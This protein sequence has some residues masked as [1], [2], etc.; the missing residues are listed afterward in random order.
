MKRLGFLVLVALVAIPAVAA[1]NSRE[2]VTDDV[3]GVSHPPGAQTDWLWPALLY[4]NGPLVT[5]PG[6]GAGGAD[7]SEL[8]TAL[9][10]TTLGAGHQFALGYSVSDDFEVPAG[11]WQ[12]D[13]ITFFAYQTGLTT[14]STVTGVYAQIWDGES[15]VGGSI[16]WGDLTTNLMDTTQW[17]NIYRATDSDPNNTD[18]PIMATVAMVNTTLTPGTYW[19]EWTTDGTLGSGPWAPPISILGETTTGNAKQNLAGA[20]QELVDGGTGTAQ[21]LP[22]II[23]GE[24]VPVELQSFSIE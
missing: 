18:R 13:T 11:G 15:D 2:L 17:S 24:V 9:G 1:D 19:V 10:L 16:V 21:G 22:F 3:P 23:D 4:D 6:G 20:W 14:S 7:L 8:Q 12:I 5:Q